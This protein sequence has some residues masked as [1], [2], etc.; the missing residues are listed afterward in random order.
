M[1]FSQDRNEI[2]K[3]FRASWKKLIDKQPIEPLEALIGGVVAMHPEYHSMLETEQSDLDKDYLPE[4]G[5]GNPFLH[6]GMHI[7]LREQRDSNRPNG[8]REIYKEILIK[9]GDPHETE[10]MMM[11]CLGETLWQAQ[12]TGQLPDDQAYLDCLTQLI[13]KS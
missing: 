1:F 3:F 8:I 12:K 4:E 6:M 11:D 5:Q 13:N 2:R 9:L 7:T 10:H